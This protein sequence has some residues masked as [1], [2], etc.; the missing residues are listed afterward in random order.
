MWIISEHDEVFPFL[1][2][3]DQRP[4]EEGNLRSSTPGRFHPT[5]RLARLPSTVL[6][7]NKWSEHEFMGAR[8]KGEGVQGATIAPLEK[9]WSYEK[10][11]FLVSFVT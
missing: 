7:R 9:F 5:R 8:G 3:K 10:V 6:S 1:E 11:K 4:R 2:S